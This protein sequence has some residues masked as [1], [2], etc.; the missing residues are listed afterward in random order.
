MGSC[1]AWWL[2][3]ASGMGETVTMGMLMMGMS[4]RVMWDRC[5]KVMM[6]MSMK[7]MW[8]IRMRLHTIMRNIIMMRRDMADMGMLVL[9]RMAM[10]V[11]PERLSL[12]LSRHGRLVL[13]L[14]R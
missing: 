1:C 3:V 10:R 8:N 2:V 11:M 14:R 9:W 13:W 5:M 4:M 12:L 7:V 6:D